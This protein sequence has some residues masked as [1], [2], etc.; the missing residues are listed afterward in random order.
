MNIRSALARIISRQPPALP[1]PEPAREDL[2]GRHYKPAPTPPAAPGSDPEPKAGGRRRRRNRHRGGKRREWTPEQDARVLAIPIVPVGLRTKTKGETTIQ[3]LARELG[4]TETAVRS[5]RSELN[6]RLD[7]EAAREAARREQDERDR[8]IVA[9]VAAGA[10][11]KE[12]GRRYGIS[13]QAVARLVERR[14]PDLNLRTTERGRNRRLV[15][16][17]IARDLAPRILD[18]AAVGD[19]LTLTAAEVSALAEAGGSE[20]AASRL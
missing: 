13:P 18:A 12:A 1:A 6:K 7:R 20:G 8:A 4:R 10:S 16:G 2:S 11:L 5:R 3:R 19:G 17:R 15:K 14:A 9:A